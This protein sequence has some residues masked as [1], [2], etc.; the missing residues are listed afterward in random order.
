M[1]CLAVNYRGLFGVISCEFVDR[2]WPENR[3]H[4]T[5]RSNTNTKSH[6]M[7]APRVRDTAQAQDAEVT[8]S[9][10]VT[11]EQEIRTLRQTF[12]VGTNWFDCAKIPLSIFLNSAIVGA[13]Q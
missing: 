1:V 10:I 9:M 5:T 2:L 11:L 7:T 3:I 4:E 13:Y 8:Q 12:S 6:E